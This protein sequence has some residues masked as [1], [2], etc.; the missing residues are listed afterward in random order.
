[1]MK[2]LVKNEQR[3]HL[4]GCPEGVSPSTR[5]ARLTAGQRRDG[6]K[7]DTLPW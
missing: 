6:G 5:R 2:G 1:M 3:R 4:A 7:S